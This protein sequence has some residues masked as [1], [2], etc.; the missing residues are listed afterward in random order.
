MSM[1][2][3]AIFRGV[4]AGTLILPRLRDVE[5][6]PPLPKGFHYT[7]LRGLSFRQFQAVNGELKPDDTWEPEDVVAWFM[8]ENL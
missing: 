6:L 1:T 2:P 3:E 5:G 4:E 8:D 7:D